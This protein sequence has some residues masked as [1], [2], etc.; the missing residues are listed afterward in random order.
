[1]LEILLERQVNVGK[2]R[3]RRDQFRHALDDREIRAVV[4]ALLGDERVITPRHERAVVG[5]LFLG[6]DLLHHRLRGRLLVFAAER[7]YNR[8]R[9]D[10]RVESLRKSALRAD[11]E[12]ARKRRI[13]SREA[14]RD[15]FFISVGARGDDVD[16]LF[17]AVGIK[18][19]AAD[20]DDLLSV[21]RHREARIVL[22]DGDLH[23]AEVFFLRERDERV[24]V[25]CFDDDGHSLLRFADGEFRS[26]EAVVFL[27]HG[28]KIDRK[29]VGKLADRNRNA[30]RAEVVAPLYHAARVAIPEQALELSFLGRVAF[31][32]L[33]AACFD[34]VRV[35]RFRRSRRAAD[36]VA[37]RGAAEKDHDVARRRHF[38]PDVFS[39]RRGDD[40]AD[41]HTF[42]GVAGVV[43]LVDDARRK[44]D[45]VAV[46]R[47]ARRR[48]RDDLPLRQFAF[49]RLR[50]GRRGIC[51]ARHPHRAVDVRAPGERIA[52]RAADARRGAAERLDLRR[53][54][55]RLVFEK[56]QPR[57]DL[58][59][60][61]DVDLHR[62]GVDLVGDVELFE[63]ARAAQIFDSHRRHIHKADGL[64]YAEFFS[65]RYVFF[66]FIL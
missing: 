48:G 38:A 42:C 25:L 30:A 17:R 19:L 21:P 16:V 5:M 62:A 46:R 47:I 4:R 33:R 10:R 1:M 36:A 18:E 6:R 12:V 27:R 66:V 59:V 65:Y 7:H 63:L 22:D 54:V 35:V 55:V 44:S 53:V 43:Y 40:R 51:R 32:H 3:A 24:G 15:L 58:S 41:L 23:G 31:L 37:S 50:H 56:K 2:F 57:L 9:A 39:R 29:S 11:V 60:D 28:V 13:P 20:V 45:L 8:P 26:V 49:H 14:L 34:R 61:F 64:F 52:D